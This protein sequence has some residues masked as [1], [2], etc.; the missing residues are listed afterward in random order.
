M[1]LGAVITA[2]LTQASAPAL[3]PPELFKKVSRSVVIVRTA[4]DGGSSQ[5]SGVVVGAGR[6]ATNAHVLG[7]AQ[8]ATVSYGTKQWRTSSIWRDPDRDV[9][10]LSIQGLD[11]PVPEIGSAATIEVGSHV[12]VVGAPRGLELSLSDGLV[13]GLRAIDSGAPLVQLTAPISPGSSGGGVFDAQARLIGLATLILKD[14][15]NLNFAL[16]IDWIAAPLGEPR[17]ASDPT[18]A[19]SPGREGVDS[20]VD[21]ADG[22]IP[23]SLPGEAIALRVGLEKLHSRLKLLR[24]QLPKVT[25]FLTKPH[26]AAREQPL[27]PRKK[28]RSEILREVHDLFPLSELL[29]LRKFPEGSKA[30]DTVL[31]IEIDIETDTKKLRA[32]LDEAI[33]FVDRLATCARRVEEKGAEA[34]GEC[35]GL[36]G[37]CPAEVGGAK[38]EL[39]YFRTA[40]DYALVRDAVATPEDMPEEGKGP[41]KFEHDSMGQ[42]FSEERTSREAQAVRA[43]VQGVRFAACKTALHFMGAFAE[44]KVLMDWEHQSPWFSTTLVPFQ[45]ICTMPLAVQPTSRRLHE[46]ATKYP[47]DGSLRLAADAVG[48]HCQFA[49]QRT[50]S[51]V[52]KIRDKWALEYLDEDCR[53]QRATAADV[54]REAER[55]GRTRSELLKEEHLL[56]ADRI[57]ACAAASA[58]GYQWETEA[59]DVSDCRRR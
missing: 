12:Y 56:L 25:A 5:G 38:G 34:W 7:A 6:V 30:G 45:S 9:A 23:L 24:T 32:Q 42:L 19:S 49:A 55:I 20:G 21:S 3:P 22:F 13:A 39:F 1:I 33:A 4:V 10:L 14:S 53:P 15:Q 44:T 35:T 26:L 40:Q 41:W 43:D 46:L 31:K 27:S 57:E 17:S 29:D 51:H 28:T 11:L 16:P 54:R 2:L 59:L 36:S 47:S 18:I 8:E 48:S 37:L 50:C 52:F 58:I